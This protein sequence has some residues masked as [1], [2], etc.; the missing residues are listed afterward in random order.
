MIVNEFFIIYFIEN[1][2]NDAS[3]ANFPN[4]WCSKS[5]EVVKINLKILLVLFVSIDQCSVLRRA[6]RKITCLAR[7]KEVKQ[8]PGNCPH[9]SVEWKT[10]ETEK[11]QQDFLFIGLALSA[12]PHIFIIRF[13]FKN[14]MTP[15]WL[16]YLL[17]WYFYSNIF[18]AS[19]LIQCIL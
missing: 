4:I 8:Q 13:I 15:M 7:I 2:M 3:I 19:S 5:Q 1:L 16:Q 17:E 12:S 9:I 14:S 6:I 10:I 18:Y 11:F